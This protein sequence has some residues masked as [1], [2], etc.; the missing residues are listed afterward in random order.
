MIEAVDVTITVTASGAQLRWSATASTTP[1]T[2]DCYDSIQAVKTPRR[3]SSASID[4][5]PCFA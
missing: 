2:P 1:H 3:R 5:M 4:R